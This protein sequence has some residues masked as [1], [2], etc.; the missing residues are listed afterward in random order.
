MLKTQRQSPPTPPPLTPFER[1]GTKSVCPIQVRSLKK[2][3]SGKNASVEEEDTWVG[4]IKHLRH[5]D[6]GS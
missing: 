6:A 4:V 5:D 1:F 3:N 2:K